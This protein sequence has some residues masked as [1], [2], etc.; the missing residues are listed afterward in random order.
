M[1]TNEVL[2]LMQA[3][4]SV[5]AFT[6]KPIEGDVFEA[7]R[8]EILKINTISGL[9]FQLVA[10]EPGA[11]TGFKAG[12]GRFINVRNYVGLV[13]LIGP[14]LDEGVGFWGERLVMKA[15][16]LGLNTCWTAMSFSRLRAK[17]VEPFGEKLVCMLAIGY[18]DTQGEPHTSRPIEALCTMPEDAPLWFLNGMKGAMLAPTAMNQQHF[19]VSLDADGLVNI[20]STGGFYAEV[21]LGIVKYAFET[22]AGKAF[23]GF[24]D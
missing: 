2:Q 17:I 15:Q 24:S 21:D 22:A 19:H 8:A 4:H 9:N 13:G 3:R 1:E 5:R 10:D 23:P 6:D 7:L 14:T 16:A 11:F 20:V 18:G 12:Y